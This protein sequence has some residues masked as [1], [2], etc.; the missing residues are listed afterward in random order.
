MF[1]SDEVVFGRSRLESKVPWVED[2]IVWIVVVIVELK[3]NGRISSFIVS[4]EW[5]FLR[6]MGEALEIERVWNVVGK[7][8]SFLQFPLRGVGLEDSV[9]DGH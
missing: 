1:L 7:M 5:D 4:D 2:S 8:G 3:F 9:V 6:V